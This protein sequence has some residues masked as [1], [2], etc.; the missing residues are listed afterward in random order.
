MKEGESVE[1]GHLL[2]SLTQIKIECE[3]Q[4]FIYLSLSFCYSK[5]LSIS[6]RT[7]SGDHQTLFYN[8]KSAKKSANLVC[9][10]MRK[11]PSLTLLCRTISL[12]NKCKWM[13]CVANNSYYIV[14]KRRWRHKLIKMKIL[15]TTKATLFS[16]QAFSDYFSKFHRHRRKLLWPFWGVWKLAVV[17][18]LVYFLASSL[19]IS[20]ALGPNDTQS[21]SK[22]KILF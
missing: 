11:M 8:K 10:K 3:T 18:I 13:I 14:K 12:A 16:L 20:S 5:F 21:N 17:V 19:L 7:S 2:I 1:K 6:W 9:K 4:A 15:R 22:G